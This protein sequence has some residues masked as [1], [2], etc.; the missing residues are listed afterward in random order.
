MDQLEANAPCPCKTKDRAR[1]VTKSTVHPLHV[2]A[3][4]TEG[5]FLG[6]MQFWTLWVRDVMPRGRPVRNSNC[7]SSNPFLSFG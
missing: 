6:L 7:T 4:T 1:I 5:H 3:I 2:C